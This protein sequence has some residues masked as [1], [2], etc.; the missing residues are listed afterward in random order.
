MLPTIF[1]NII[2][3]FIISSKDANFKLFL[4]YLLQGLYFEYCNEHMLTVTKICHHESRA[5]CG[6]KPDIIQL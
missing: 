4:V 2:I 6:D 1:Y 3:F 5:K